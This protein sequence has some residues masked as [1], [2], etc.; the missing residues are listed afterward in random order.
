MTF[1]KPPFRY[2][3]KENV[4]EKCKELCCPASV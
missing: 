3:K 4:T 1:L 2:G